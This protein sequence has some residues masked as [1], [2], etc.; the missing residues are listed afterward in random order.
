MNG[1]ELWYAWHPVQERGSGKWRWLSLVC[2]RRVWALS[3]WDSDSW[4]YGP[5]SFVFSQPETEA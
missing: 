1:W 2:R 4:I 5:A 3:H